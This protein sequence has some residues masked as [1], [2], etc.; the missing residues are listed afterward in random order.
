MPQDNESIYFNEIEDIT[1]TCGPSRIGS[2][3]TLLSEW[4]WGVEQRLQWFNKY[5]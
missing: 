5:L 1:I 3:T 4:M 2:C